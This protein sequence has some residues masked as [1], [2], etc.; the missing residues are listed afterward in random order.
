MHCKFSVYCQV[1]GL[2]HGKVW[3]LTDITVVAQR[4]I[5]Q[6]V[7]Q[8]PQKAAVQCGNIRP[9]QPPMSGMKSETST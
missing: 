6:S 4:G 2:S 3:P 1:I 8:M 9:S 5:S 7:P